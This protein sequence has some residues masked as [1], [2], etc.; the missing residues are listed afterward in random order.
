M[1]SGTSRTDT[2]TRV[3]PLPALGRTA[4]LS[5]AFSLLPVF[6]AVTYL[7]HRSSAWP[8]V[9]A[10]EAVVALVFV[11]LYVRFRRVFTA[12]TPAQFVT[13]RMLL[14]R[15]AVDRARI[16]RVIVSRV[17]RPGSTDALLHLLGVD[18]LGRRLFGLNSLFWSE[19][20]I[21]RIV[22]V[23][24]VQTLVDTMP[25][26]TAEYHRRF[27]VARGWHLR[28]PV[29]VGSTVAALGLLVV[30]VFLLQQVVRPV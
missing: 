7:S 5:G 28:P 12:V 14:S 10:V 29:L 3:S 6:A 16:D 15:V 21:Q 9:V 1:P 27:P 18:A 20:D 26:S 4:L 2:E 13:R 11:T 25:I 24:D 19:D 17:Y 30:I 22:D 23:L 8:W